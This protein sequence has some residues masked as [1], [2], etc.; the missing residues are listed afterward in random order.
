MGTG[1]RIVEEVEQFVRD[2]EAAE[3]L[4]ISLRA[5]HSHVA[6]GTLPSYK[7]GGSRRFRKS[8]LAAALVRVS[9]TSEVL[10]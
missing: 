2:R 3:F 5:L 4:A 8:E 6:A 10:R 1:P 9:S 7:I